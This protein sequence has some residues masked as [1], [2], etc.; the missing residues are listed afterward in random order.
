MLYKVSE[1]SAEKEQKQNDCLIRAEHLF[2]SYDDGKNCSLNDISLEIHS[3]R[4]IAFLGANGAGK[5]TFFL[6]LNGILKPEKGHLFFRGTPYSYKQK[7]LL[8]LRQKVGIVFQNPDDQ[9]FSASVCQEISFGLFNLGMNASQVQPLVD[10][11]IDNM[12]L[13]SCCH[14]PVHTLS[15]GQKKQVAIAD[16]LVMKPELI[17][18]DEPVSSLDP[19]H[20]D[21]VHGWIEQMTLDGMTVLQSTHDVDYALHWADEVILL[22]E[23]RI[24]AHTDPVTLFCDEALL[25][26]AN[27][28]QPDCLR[29]FFSLCR[30]KI[31]PDTLPI[32]RTL[33][34]LE[35]YLEETLERK[36]S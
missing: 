21:L 1:T 16:I 10:Q 28:K 8:S 24:L 35:L 27:L 17:I 18:L 7:D 22:H 20:T 34:T 3:G 15:G 26:R 13:R 11:M 9:L 32:P 29:L 4:K 5:S 31:L 2:Y 23:G 30:K 12:G 6:C 36:E 25:A 33:Q 14:K 19:K